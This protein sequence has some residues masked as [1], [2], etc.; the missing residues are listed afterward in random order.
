MV[1][2]CICDFSSTVDSGK[3][4]T[5]PQEFKV[6]AENKNCFDPENYLL[7]W[8]NTFDQVLIG[9]GGAKGQFF[10]PLPPAFSVASLALHLVR[11]V[12]I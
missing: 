4:E 9:N 2:E 8:L 5:Q 1:Q 12:K 6:L 3:L 10:P 11:V 7:V